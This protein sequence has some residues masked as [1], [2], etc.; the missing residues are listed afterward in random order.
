MLKKIAFVTAEYGGVVSAGGVAKMVKEL[1][2]TIVN[3]FDHDCTVV[4]PYF[5][6][7]HSGRFLNI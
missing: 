6:F 1:A 3:E 4:M 2:E 7:D 5:Q